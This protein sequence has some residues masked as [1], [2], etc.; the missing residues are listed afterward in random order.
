MWEALSGSMSLSGNSYCEILRTEAG[1]VAGLYPLSPLMTEPVRMPNGKLAYKTS[2]GMAS[3][4]TRIIN[5]E[6]HASLPHSSPGM[7]FAASLLSSRHVR[8]SAWRAQAN[9]SEPTSSVVAAG[10]LDF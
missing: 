2:V 10:L 5:A 8:P 6:R 9:A 4:K 7:A 3:G 1:K